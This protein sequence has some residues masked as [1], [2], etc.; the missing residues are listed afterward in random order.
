M[1]LF[2]ILALGFFLGMRHATDSDHV[3]AVTTIVSR[4]RTARAALWVGALWGLGHSATILTVGG[5]I[6]L[7]GWVI[8]PR[9]GLSM[10]MSVAVML[11]V[12]GAMN[13]SG[14]LSRINQ[15]A[16]RHQHAGDD[17]E[18]AAHVHVR[19]PLRPLVIGVVHGLAG[20]AAVTLL[21]LTTIK[22][23]GM[24]LFYLAI[25]GAGTVAGMMLLTLA[26]AL[27]ISALSR[28]FAHA[29][30]QMARVTGLVSI[31]FGLFL[32]Y[33]IGVAD[34]LLFGVPQWSPH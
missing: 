33:R 30:Q 24:A 22:S 23:A 26:M 15:L 34:G 8:P 12:L 6:V 31:A 21:V 18:S 2:A 17:D 10:E 14:T 27:P 25:F 19:G 29:E 7:F 11:I 20:S 13:L 28:R 5:A 1:T 16:R 4:A 9:L 3:I 32:A